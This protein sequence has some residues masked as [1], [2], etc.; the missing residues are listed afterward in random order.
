[1][2]LK[3]VHIFSYYISFCGLHWYHH[4]IVNIPISSIIKEQFKWVELTNAWFYICELF[5]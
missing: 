5:L 3:K 4:S 2:I 1:M